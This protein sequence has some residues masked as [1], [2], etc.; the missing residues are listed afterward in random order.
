VSFMLNFIYAECH[1]CW[2]S[3]Y[4]IVMLIVITLNVVV[5]SVIILSVVAFS[6]TDN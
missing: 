1:L 4:F 3:I 5:L 2:M 6:K